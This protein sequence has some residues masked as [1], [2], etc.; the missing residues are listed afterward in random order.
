MI[1]EPGSGAQASRCSR[2]QPGQHLAL[3]GIRLAGA[4]DA[5]AQEQ[6]GA[7]VRAGGE[8]VG[9]V[10][11]AD[12]GVVDGLE[13]PRPQRHHAQS[14]AGRG[15]GAVEIALEAV[16]SHQVDDVHAAVHGREPVRDD[17]RVEVVRVRLGLCLAAGVGGVRRATLADVQ[18][19]RVL[20]PHLDVETD[21][22]TAR[23]VAVHLEDCRR[24]GLEAATYREIKN[25]LARREKLD[26]TAVTRLRSFSQSLLHDP[27][28]RDGGGAQGAVPG[29]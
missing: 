21:E 5:A 11:E 7:G 28:G 12:T 16:E 9:Q 13:G 27:D 2:V 14:L 18:V 6:I 26:A 10:P 17:H 1:R 22:V 15:G 25:S 23:R 20:Q 3:R 29:E 19:A 8:V 24:C 4:G